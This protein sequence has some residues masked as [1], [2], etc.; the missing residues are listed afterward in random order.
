VVCVGSVQFVWEISTKVVILPA[1]T[2]IF[3]SDGSRSEKITGAS[4]RCFRGG[5]SFFKWIQ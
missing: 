1:G 3:S 2:G 5:I 4:G